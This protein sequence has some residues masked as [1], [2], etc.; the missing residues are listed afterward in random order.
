MARYVA[1][2]KGINVG[3][4]RVKMERL[5]GPFE[6]LG[7]SSVSTLLASGNVV[8]EAPGDDAPALEAAIEGQLKASLGFEVETFVRTA[9]EVAAVAGSRP[10]GVEVVEGPGV[11]VQ[12]LF[13]RVAPGEEA[14]RAV[15]ACRTDCDDF[16]AI[17]RELFWLRRGRV[18]DSEVPWAML[19]RKVL[20]SGTMRNLETVRKL[21]R[22][23]ASA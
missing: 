3:G 12:V 23:G 18:S 1:F 10:F 4:R 8:F 9:E 2:L 14:E 22:P 6:E 5:R 19:G 21:A 13:L 16:R 17:G 15:M 20:G 11:S 7:F